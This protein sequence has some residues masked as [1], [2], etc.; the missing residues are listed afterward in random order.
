MKLVELTSPNGT[1]CAIN[2]ARIESVVHYNNLTP[3]PEVRVFMVG[4]PPDEYWTPLGTYADIVASIN[5]AL[6]GDPK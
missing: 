3:N 2:P 1:V 5:A 6:D 4:A